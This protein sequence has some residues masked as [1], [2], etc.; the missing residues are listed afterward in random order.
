MYL[1]AKV[2]GAWLENDASVVAVVVLSDRGQPELPH[3]V[4]AGEDAPAAAHRAGGR[5]S[6]VLPIEFSG[7]CRTNKQS[8]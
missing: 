5:A 4:G 7:Q 3:Q 8:T 2:A 1:F 6:T